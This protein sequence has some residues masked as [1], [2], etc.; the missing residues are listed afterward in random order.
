MRST[1]CLKIRTCTTIRCCPERMRLA[2]P[3]MKTSTT[4]S[5]R[6]YTTFCSDLRKVADEYDAVLIGETWT[7]NIDE[8]KH[9]YGDHSNEL[10]MPMDFMFT[11][12]QQA[13]GARISPADCGRRRCR[14]LAGFRDQQSR[15]RALLQPLRRRQTQ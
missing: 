1:R 9:Y 8:L 4:T 13:F 12:C 10:Q 5:C 11:H 2:I 7:E 3:N 15:Y 6:R 14:G